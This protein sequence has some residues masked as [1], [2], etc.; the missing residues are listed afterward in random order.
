MSSADNSKIAGNF[1]FH[2]QPMPRL[3]KLIASISGLRMRNGLKSPHLS[4]TTT[5]I[6]LSHVLHTFD[7]SDI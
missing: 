5:Y 2:C 3:T 7:F 6:K 1:P 4:M